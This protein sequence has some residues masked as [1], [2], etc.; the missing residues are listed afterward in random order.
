MYCSLDTGLYP[1]RDS[2]SKSTISEGKSSWN[3]PD[4]R[5]NFHSLETSNKVLLP[6]RWEPLVEEEYSHG[7]LQGRYRTIYFQ[8]DGSRTI[9]KAGWIRCRGVR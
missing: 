7:K 4:K 1:I 9:G 2:F 5:E 3:P 8:K 6:S